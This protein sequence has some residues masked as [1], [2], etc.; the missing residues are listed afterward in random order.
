MSAAAAVL[1]TR[2]GPLLVLVEAGVEGDRTAPVP[3]A[4]VA[5]GLRTDIDRALL[6][7]PA[8]HA[9]LGFVA[10]AVAD[11][12]GGRDL[13]ALERVPVSLPGGSFRPE[14]WRVLRDVAAGQTV[15]YRELAAMAGRER[16]FRAA[17]SA[18]AHNPVAPFVP[19][20]R[21]IRSDGGLGEYGYR[22]AVKRAMLQHE[23]AI[24]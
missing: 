5:S 13:D 19:C 24:R 11:W 6:A 15:T 9:F 4:V 17:G 2:F 22:P 10:E 20:H 21:V 8:D 12:D 16:A 23:G 14:V 7:E 1:P 18:C 3:G